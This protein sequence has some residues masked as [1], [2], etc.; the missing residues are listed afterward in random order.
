M[1]LTEADLGRLS[2]RF[3]GLWLSAAGN[4]FGELSFCADYDKEKREFVIGYGD[5]HCVVAE[6]TA[7]IDDVFEIEIHLSSGAV[8][9]V[10]AGAWPRVSEI[11]GRCEAIA[12]KQG[13]EILD[14]HM[15]S[16]GFC[17]L[18]IQS[19]PD[20]NLLLSKFVA[21]LVIPFFYR[22]AYVERF[23]LAAAR[24][25]LWGEY[26]HGDDGKNEYIREAHPSLRRSVTFRR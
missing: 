1:K 20:P 22:L 9:F 19:S 18:G 23:G 17:C 12:R 4:M 2:K 14:L 13:I 7:H 16:D 8:S 3:P 26:A 11:G 5:D 21:R 10:E 24:N 25:N 6:S 15:Y